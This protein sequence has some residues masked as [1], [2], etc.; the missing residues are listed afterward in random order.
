MTV[1]PSAR[2]FHH[3]ADETRRFSGSRRG[4]DQ[5]VAVELPDDRVAVRLVG[6]SRAGRWSSIEASVSGEHRIRCVSDLLSL[7]SALP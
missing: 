4:F 3:A 6:E 5:E 7:S 1:S 2:E